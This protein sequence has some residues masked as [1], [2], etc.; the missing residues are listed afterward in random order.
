MKLVG[1]NPDILILDEHMNGLDNQEVDE[2][3][4]LLLQMKAQGKTILLTSHNSEDI[5]I[6][7]DAVYEMDGGN[8]KSN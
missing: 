1:L 6:L 5:R 4:K 3:R 2:V 8:L 7:C